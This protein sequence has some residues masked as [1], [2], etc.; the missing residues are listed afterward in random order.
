MKRT[1]IVT[2]S[3]A[4]VS[5]LVVVF[6][7]FGVLTTTPHDKEHVANREPDKEGEN[8][9]HG[10]PAED[11]TAAHTEHDSRGLTMQ[12]RSDSA[13][14]QK[15]EA[16]GYKT[17]KSNLAKFEAPHDGSG[18]MPYPDG[19]TESPN[20]D[21]R[22]VLQRRGESYYVYDAAKDS[23]LKLPFEYGL[24]PEN[25]LHGEQSISWQWLDEHRIIGVQEAW[26]ESDPNPLT[27]PEFLSAGLSTTEISV[28]MPT[29]SF[30]FVYDTR[31]PGVI[32]EINPPLI[33]AGYAVRLD[34]ISPGGIVELSACTPLGYYGVVGEPEE[35]AT[36]HPL[37]IPLGQFEIRD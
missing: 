23:M 1:I 21:G 18:K 26:R 6:I 7:R 22:L 3:V 9:T 11:G 4:L 16:V 20:R 2:A 10:E 33:P 19:K 14:R 5:L 15:R 24:D 30:L 12:D 13:A 35:G 28:A 34:A 31:A 32:Y 17:I 37:T 29:C 8:R 25:G 27:S 36:R